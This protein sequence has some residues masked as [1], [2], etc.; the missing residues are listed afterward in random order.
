MFVSLS[1]EQSTWRA[2][3]SSAA[4]PAGS[5]VGAVAVELNEID[6]C[7]ISFSVRHTS[8]EFSRQTQL[9][10]PEKKNTSAVITSLITGGTVFSFFECFY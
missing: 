1:L 9:R 5:P 4:S 10:P 6:C 7:T 3:E 8:V 2:S